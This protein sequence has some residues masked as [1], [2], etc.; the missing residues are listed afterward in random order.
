MISPRIKTLSFKLLSVSS[1]IALIIVISEIT[2]CAL[3]SQE[4]DKD[5][6]LTPHSE[7]RRELP[8]F[9]SEIIASTPTTLFASQPY[10]PVD[11]NALFPMDHIDQTAKDLNLPVFNYEGVLTKMHSD[12][13][14]P[15]Y[16]VHVQLDSLGRR[17][18][19]PVGTHQPTRHLVIMGC[20]YAFGETVEA[21]HTLAAQL[22]KLLNQKTYNLNFSGYGPNDVLARS[23]THGFMNEIIPAQGA[24]LYIY[25]DNQIKRSV[26]AMSVVGNWGQ[27]SAVLEAEDTYSFRHTGTHARERWI[28]TLML[29]ILWKSYTV[30]FFKMDLPFRITENDY[31]RMAREL[32]AI[33]KLY[34]EKTSRENPLIVVIYPEH[35]KET[36]LGLLKKALAAH[37]VLFIDYSAIAMDVRIPEQARTDYDG[38]PTAAAYRHLAHLLNEDLQKYLNPTL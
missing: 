14:R 30:Q 2:S 15:I 24:S 38:H 34:Q 6:F 19:D 10:A 28:R 25:T 13:S 1:A 31:D 9:S 35:L 12:R 23:L 20:S 21:Q 29:R 5:S 7:P 26:G 8:V 37:S 3:L 22:G 18:A 33:E 36:N 16:R 17:V 27:K 11:K 32:K 4:I